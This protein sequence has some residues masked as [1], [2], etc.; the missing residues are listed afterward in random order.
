MGTVTKDSKDWQQQ[1]PHFTF[2]KLFYI[3]CF[4]SLTYQMTLIL[5]YLTVNT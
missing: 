4:I 1:F 2:I 3:C 5:F